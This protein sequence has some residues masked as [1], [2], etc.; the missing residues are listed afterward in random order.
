MDS[1]VYLPVGFK[2]DFYLSNDLQKASFYI[3]IP[4]S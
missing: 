3:K 2:Q 1:G 4:F